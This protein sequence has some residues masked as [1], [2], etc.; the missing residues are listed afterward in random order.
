MRLRKHTRRRY[1]RRR[2]GLAGEV[3]HE[4]QTEKGAWA[5]LPDEHDVEV[6]FEENDDPGYAGEDE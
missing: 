1:R 5:I 4:T 2:P 3:R 6:D